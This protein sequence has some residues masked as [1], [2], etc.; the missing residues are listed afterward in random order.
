FYL[1]N[2]R[3]KDAIDRSRSSL[4]TAMNSV[5]AGATNEFVAFDVREAI[6]VLSEITGEVTNEEILN[7]I[8][9]RFCIGK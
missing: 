5:N 2:R 6:E 9:G 8:F 7:S 3:H 1:T 4:E